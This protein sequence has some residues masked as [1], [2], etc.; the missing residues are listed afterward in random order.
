MNT[1]GINARSTKVGAAVITTKN[2]LFFQT[3]LLEVIAFTEFVV[4]D[5][6]VVERVVVVVDSIVV[7]KVLSIIGF[8]VVDTTLVTF[9]VLIVGFS[10]VVVS[11]SNF[12][13][14]KLM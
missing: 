7:A 3:L 13:S 9:V 14:L 10:V 11:S 4:L 12:S 2:V 1:N 8:A 5:S 6:V